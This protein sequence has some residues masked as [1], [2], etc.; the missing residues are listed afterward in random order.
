MK[1]SSSEIKGAIIG[2]LLGDGF[3]TRPNR[4]TGNCSIMFHHGIKQEQYLD[5]KAKIFSSI[6]NTTVRKSYGQSNLNGKIFKSVKLQTNHSI[7][8]KKIRNLLY[9]ED[10]KIV[11]K[12]V[13]NKLTP[14]GL[15]L[16]FCDDGDLVVSERKERTVEGKPKQYQFRARLWTCSFTY[17]EHLLLQE[18]FQTKWNIRVVINKCNRKW[19]G[20]ILEYHNLRFPSL[21]FKKF[22]EIIKP[23][24]PDCMKYKIDYEGR[25]AA[26]RLEEKS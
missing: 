7:F 2:T 9:K 25:I 24:V 3:V 19:K 6:S 5:Y 23:H 14:L 11:T 16:L 13:L 26:K 1:L 18:Y 10:K 15:A 12:K 20:Q 21:E 8:F 17:E 22:V 4:G